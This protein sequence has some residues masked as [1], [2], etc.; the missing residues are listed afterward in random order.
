MMK[1]FNTFKMLSFILLGTALLLSPAQKAFAEPA[2]LPEVP[3]KGMVTMVDFGAP[4][5]AP[6]KAMVNTPGPLLA[7]L[8]GVHAMTDV[9]GFGLA[10]HLLEMARGSGLTAVVEFDSLPLIEE[11]VRHARDGIVTGASARNWSSYRREV[12]LPDEM[13]DW[14]RNL[15]T[16]PQTSGGLLVA[17]SADALLGVRGLFAVEGFQ[18]AVIGRFEAGPARLKVLKRNL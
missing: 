14:Q 6:C 16:D 2:V 12:D 10:G 7:K 13:P 18:P 5:C 3:V 11:A 4:F 9:T 17:C 8:D 15:L 1:T